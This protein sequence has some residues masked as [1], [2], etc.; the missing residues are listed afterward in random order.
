MKKQFLVLNITMTLGL[1]SVFALPT[2]KADSISGIQSQRSSIQANIKQANQEILLVQD[3]LSKLN[4]QLKRAEQAMIDNQNMIVKTENDITAANLEI[5]KLEE[6]VASLQEAIAK[7]NEILKERARSYQVTGGDVKYL[8][9][10]FGSTSFSDFVDRVGAVVTFM[11]ADKDLMEKFE[12]DKKAVEEKQASIQTKLVELTNLKTELDGM[13][14]QITEQQQQNEL[15]REELKQKEAAGLA[16]K[17]DL[18]QQDSSLA[19]QEAQM[20]ANLAP[21]VATTTGSSTSTKSSTT[22]SSYIPAAP[23][24]GSG[25]VSIVTT[26][27][28]RYIGN[29]VYVFGGG[30]TAYDVANG[31][32]DCSGFVHWAFA[33]AGISVGASTDSLKNA[34]RK[35]STSEMRPGD[36][37]FFNT[38]KTD[39]H[40]GIY[41]GGGNF[42]GSQNST[43]VAVANMSSGYW[44]NHFAGK[45]VRIIE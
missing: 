12:A 21:R 22:T 44:A 45:V 10:V 1:G 40:V 6:E 20:A 32:F 43:G 27:G 33:Q 17:A 9:V 35:V 39:G 5:Q 34:G 7:R 23:V 25:A 28:N 36:L 41:L 37:V 42:I 18:Q 24:Q 2:A 29:S 3:E 13:R 31:R 30:R 26:V 38:Y 19:S 4:E 16:S 11:N 8:D 15:L 14:A